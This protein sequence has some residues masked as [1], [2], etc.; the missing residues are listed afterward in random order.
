MLGK[1]SPY[2]SASLAAVLALFSQQTALLRMFLNALC[3]A[4][5]LAPRSVIT[6]HSGSGTKQAVLPGSSAADGIGVVTP[7]YRVPR[8]PGVF[9]QAMEAQS[10]WTSWFWMTSSY[11]TL[12]SLLLNSKLL[13]KWLLK[14]EPA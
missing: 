2:G 3:F 6:Q 5:A 4:P 9:L 7:K 1:V 8:E 12:A 13:E 14:L 11:K 10:C